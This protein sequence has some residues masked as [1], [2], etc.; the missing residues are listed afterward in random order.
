LGLFILVRA[1]ALLSQI[2]IVFADETRS[3]HQVL[4]IGLATGVLPDV[5]LFCA[6]WWCMFRSRIIARRV[7][8][9][10]SERSDA[11]HLTELVLAAVGVYMVFAI[12]PNVISTVIQIA[13][14]TSGTED[15]V[16]DVLIAGNLQRLLEV[17]AESVQ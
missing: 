12:L 7:F 16:R 1:V 3:S 13:W 17:T 15:T 11:D 6:A 8:G 2:G 14:A 10:D 9:F 4:Y 5:I